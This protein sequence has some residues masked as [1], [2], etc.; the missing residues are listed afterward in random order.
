MPPLKGIDRGL[1]GKALK[2]LE[3]SG[4]GRRVAIVDASYNIPGWA[5][6]VTYRG[7]TSLQALLGILSLVPFENEIWLMVPDGNG[8]QTT[9]DE[10]GPFCDDAVDALDKT[11]DYPHITA[12]HRFDSVSDGET[13][14][15]FYPLANDST[16]DTLFIRTVDR[17]PYACASFIIGH[18]QINE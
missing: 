11:F 10:S 15:G 9:D 14:I 1:T 6:V 4:H 7:E 8:G 5:Q 17:M 16:T 12:V 2:A 18:M 3:E 13:E